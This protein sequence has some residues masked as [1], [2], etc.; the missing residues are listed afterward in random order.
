MR[1]INRT[2]N[3]KQEECG[4]FLGLSTKHGTGFCARL[5]CPSQFLVADI[6]CAN[7]KRNIPGVGFYFGLE[8]LLLSFLRFQL[9]IAQDLELWS[10][11]SWRDLVVGSRNNI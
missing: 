10:L 11:F 9:C 3:Q 5:G 2:L 6:D 8:V 7:I 1:K 4:Q